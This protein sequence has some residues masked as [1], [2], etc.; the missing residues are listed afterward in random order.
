MF[1]RPGKN[2][3]EK[4]GGAPFYKEEQ[5][6]PSAYPYGHSSQESG[7]VSSR[8]FETPLVNSPASRPSHLGSE[9]N[10]QTEESWISKKTTPL[11]HPFQGIKKGEDPETTLG[12]GVTFRGE[13]R[14]ERLLRIDGLFE[15]ELLSKG[16]VIVGPKGTL[17]ANIN[18]KE[19]II[20]G[21]VIG[22]ITVEGRLELRQGAS[23]EGD[24]KAASLS[25]DDGVKIM[26]LVEVD[27]ANET[28]Q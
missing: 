7:D 19:A 11:P 1:R 20:E 14:F 2:S 25:V 21:K 24:I 27:V 13:L 26:G 12:E 28:V 3:N 6:S 17:K 18:L 10:W 23:V 15:G 9:R 16:K 4:E 22:N 5:S 8:V